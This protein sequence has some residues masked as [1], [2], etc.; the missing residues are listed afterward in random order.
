MWMSL[1]GFV[2]ILAIAFF[3]GLQGLFSSLIMC[4]LTIL[5]AGLA[6]GTYDSIFSSFLIDT[7]PEYGQAI[8]LMAVFILSLLILRVL[9]DMFISGN[10]V[11]PVWVERIGGG[12]FGLITGVVMVG[13]LQIAFQLLPFDADLLGFN[14]FAAFKPGTGQEIEPDDLKKTPADQIEWRRQNLTL[15]PDGF[16]VSLA[17]TLSRGAL[18]GRAQFAALHPDF[19]EEL[20]W[21][22][23][24]AQRE[25]RH[26]VPAD[27]LQVKK[28]SLL[29]DGKLLRKRLDR[30][31]QSTTIE[32]IQAPELDHQWLAV[33]VRVDYDARDEDGYHRFSPTQVRVVGERRGVVGRTHQYFLHG[34]GHAAEGAASS[35]DFQ[36]MALR[37]NEPVIVKA[38]TRGNE[39]DF[40]FEVPDDFEPWFVEFKSTARA[41]VP[42]IKPTGESVS[43][44]PVAK[45][46][47]PIGTSPEPEP[48]KPA[49]AVKEEYVPVK[50]RGG[51]VSARYADRAR[52]DDQLPFALPAE[53]LKRQGASLSGD[54]LREGHAVVAFPEQE[55]PA[56]G[57][58]TRLGVP[59][60]R[61][62]LRLQAEARHAGSVLGGALSVSVRTLGQYLIVDEKGGKYHRIG[63]IAV[64]DVGGERYVEIQYWPNATIPERCIQPARKVRDQHLR[65]DYLVFYLYLMPPGSKPIRFESGRGGEDLRRL[66]LVAPP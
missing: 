36:H 26:V 17:S 34:E 24:A 35:N 13:M 22:R 23:S 61:R 6:F 9:S 33:K 40:V 12:V 20:Q 66:N 64:A 15:N 30:S 21:R 58:V 57:A 45:A 56:D 5:C 50:K 44:E 10:M 38:E 32:P 16:V 2:L 29:P 19:L 8:A 60:N 52:F 18:S 4:V 51:R 11:F 27:S 46:T 42:E 53:V 28:A 7:Q 43:E 37:R 59:E 14:R 3:Q 48:A 63:Q 39:F 41:E 65:G 25:S 55:P 47:P 54:V 31:G 49:E 1:F 62:L